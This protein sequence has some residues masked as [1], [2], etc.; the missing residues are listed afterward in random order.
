MPRGKQRGKRSEIPLN[1][2]AANGWGVAVA[3]G[4]PVVAARKIKA[5]FR[6][7]ATLRH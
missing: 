4:M 7:W 6:S 2:N 5:L 3:D 1:L